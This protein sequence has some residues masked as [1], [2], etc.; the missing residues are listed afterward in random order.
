MT[1]H[2]LVHYD[3][4]T[5]LGANRGQLLRAGMAPGRVRSLYLSTPSEHS[6]VAIADGQLCLAIHF[7]V[8]SPV[9]EMFRR[10]GIAEVPTELALWA[11][12]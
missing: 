8:A 1:W 5:R 12:I 3:P 2:N 9:E 7:S 10:S 4:S 11:E 6:D